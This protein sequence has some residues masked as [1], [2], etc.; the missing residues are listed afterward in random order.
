MLNEAMVKIFLIKCYLILD[1]TVSTLKIV[2]LVLR[3]ICVFILYQFGIVL[4]VCTGASN[5]K[6]ERAGVI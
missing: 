5:T 3:A 6:E 4:D 1:I 2:I